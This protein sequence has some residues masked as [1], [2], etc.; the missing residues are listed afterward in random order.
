MIKD[1][2]QI[3]LDN[4]RKKARGLDTI[5]EYL[6]DNIIIEIR[7]KISLVSLN[8]EKVFIKKYLEDVIPKVSNLTNENLILLINLVFSQQSVSVDKACSKGI[9]HIRISNIGNFVRNEIHNDI[10]DYKNNNEDYTEDDI[11]N[12]IQ[13]HIDKRN[14]NREHKEINVKFKLNENKT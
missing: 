11:Q 12:I 8:S 4:I 2:K 3:E 1:E 6:I 7:D 13:S 9:D 5:P 14:Y 10:L